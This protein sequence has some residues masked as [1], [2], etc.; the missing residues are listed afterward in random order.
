M[1]RMNH[2]INSAGK[3]RLI[4][5]DAEQCLQEGRMQEAQDIARPL[6]PYIADC[7]EILES[8]CHRIK[9][10]L[11]V[12][13]M[14]VPCFRFCETEQLDAMA[15]TKGIFRMPKEYILA[16]RLQAHVVYAHVKP[17]APQGEEWNECNALETAQKVLDHPASDDHLNALAHHLICS[18]SP[19][20]EEKRQHMEE[21]FRIPFGDRGA[22]LTTMCCVEVWPS[23]HVITD[24]TYI[25]Q[26]LTEV[27]DPILRARL[28]FKKMTSIVN[29]LLICEKFS[30]RMDWLEQYEGQME[31]L[32]T[33]ILRIPGSE[34]SLVHAHEIFAYRFACFGEANA[35]FVHVN[36]VNELVQVLHDEELVEETK[37]IGEIVE[38]ILESVDDEEDEY[39]DDDED[40]DDEGESWKNGTNDDSDG[41][42]WFVGE[43]E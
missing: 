6:L 11:Y 23:I 36:I 42:D 25:E 15:T 7:K 8:E 30:E 9:L 37:H 27:T 13:L 28:F 5:A 43:N 17:N 34:R 10:R 14:R 29:R 40:Y 20:V 31:S 38:N 18:R 26:A 39:E 33:N 12:I 3:I 2:D 21:F 41:D 24:D 22:L 16:E 1:K 4:L 19:F 32:M 35:A